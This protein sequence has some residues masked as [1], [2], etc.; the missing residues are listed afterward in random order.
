MPRESDRAIVLRSCERLLLERIAY[1][2]WR[3]SNGVSD[4]RLNTIDHKLAR[5][6]VYVL[7]TRY[8]YVRLR[9]APRVTRF[10]ELFEQSDNAFKNDFRLSR[11]HYLE[12]HGWLL[13]TSSYT[14]D[15]GKV[16]RAQNDLMVCLF[17]LGHYG[18]ACSLVKIAKYFGICKESV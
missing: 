17:R 8:M 2:L 10:C 6:Y 13:N 12:L 15:D 5:F 1:R 4:E 9:S 11:R 16:T 18:N 7:S 14:N 3:T